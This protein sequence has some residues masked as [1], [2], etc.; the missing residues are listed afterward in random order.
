MRELFQNPSYGRWTLLRSGATDDEL[1][2]FFKDTMGKTL[3]DGWEAQRK[4]NVKQRN[5]M[6]QIGG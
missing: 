6:T 3:K 5:S 4:P 1:I 2:G